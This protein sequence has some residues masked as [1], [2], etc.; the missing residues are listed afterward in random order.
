MQAI[1]ILW[2]QYLLVHL[3]LRLFS[4]PFNEEHKKSQVFK[5]TKYLDKIL[6]IYILYFSLL[7]GT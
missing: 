5:W 2:T 6:K 3:P 7:H 4:E 1:N